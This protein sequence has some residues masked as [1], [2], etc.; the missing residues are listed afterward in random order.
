MG[1]QNPNSTSYVH[2]DE[3]NL[4]NLHKAM[5]YDADGFPHIRVTLGSDNITVSGNVNLVEAVRVNNTEAQMI[6]VYLVGNVL[7]VNQGTT[8]W[9]TTGNANVTVVGNVSGITTLPAITG[10]VG[11]SGNVSISQLP[12]ITVTNFPSNVSITSLPGITVTNFPSNVRIT[13][14]PGITGNVGVSGNV[15]IT[16]MPAISGNVSIT[17]LPA[18]GNVSI[19]RLPGVTGNVHVYGNVSVDN[20]PANVSITQMP[21]I[22]GNVNIADGGNSITVDGNVSITSM[23]AITGTV[24]L[25]TTVPPLISYADTVQMD[26]N[27]RLRVSV[28]GQQ[29]W[30]VPSV[31]KDGDL[32][33][34]E[35]FTGNSTA[36]TTF[37][38]NLASVRLTSGQ[39][40]S[41]NVQLTGTAVRASRRRHKT[42]PG[43]T[44]EWQGI[45]NWDGLQENVV[46]RI[47]MFT[48]YNGVFFE[49]NATHV[50]SVIRRR[51]TD[52]TLMEDRTPHTAWNR[53][54]MN[55]TGPTGYNWTT[56]TITA[57]VTSVVSTANV[58]VAGDGNV[59][60]VTYQLPAGEETRIGVGQKVTLTGLSPT[61]FNDTGLITSIDTVNHRANVAYVE[62]PGTYSSASG[63]R[64]TH[65]PFHHMHNYWFDFNGSR[66]GRV[67][68]GLFTDAGKIVVH[69]EL[70]GE[71][72]TQ[73]IS[74]PALMDRKEIVNTGTPVGFLPSLTVGGSGV[75]IET[76]ADINPGFGIATTA[77]PVAFN[78]NT[79]VGSEFA[80]IGVGIR[81]GEPYQRSDLQLNQFQMVDLGNLNP[82]NSGIFQWRIVLNPTTSTTP[83][84][85]NVGK[86]TRQ[87]TY[88]AGTTVSGGITLISG[89][90]Q[91]TFTGD[92]KTALNFLNMGSNIDYTDTD[93][94]VLAVKMLVGG[95]DNSS[96]V[97]VMNYTEDL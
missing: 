14:L 51:L 73:L 25:D 37:I 84:Q 49:A 29:W 4:L 32:R 16:R 83:T 30:Y 8:P 43:V 65:T 56:D 79:Q 61:R 57:N 59:Y 77:T 20:F 85:S 82:Q 78:K 7:T 60:Q 38:Q 88:S 68:F 76:T 13:D 12:G 45:V 67:R 69:D 9:V 22:T 21:G 34:I 87:L 33:I 1:V 23:P 90:A 92:V 94:V 17:Q 50:N 89:Y 95:T 47:G 36:T 40:Y 53:D 5:E 10:N 93:I 62:Y 26:S 52:G 46:K 39:Y 6:P 66:T 35:K 18:L 2:P 24:T 96:I 70:M 71:L 54:P 27:D 42:R 75:T 86:T 81:I 63:A 19:D 72:G 41:A 11:V 28:I 15:E 44:N 58:A 97:G 55:G 31:D 91:G 3:P 80:I 74:A 64:M 48:N